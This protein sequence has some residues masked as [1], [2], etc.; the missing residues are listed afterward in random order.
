MPRYN[1]AEIE[2]KWQQFW[3][4]K[5][6]FATPEMPSGEKMY[7]LDMFPY[8]SGDGLHVGHPEGY[9]ATDIVCRYARMQGKSVL[10]PMGFDAFG[11]P[12]EEHAIKTGTPPRVQTEKNIANFT[13]QLKMLGFSYD[14][15]RQIATTD[16]EYVRWTQWI[17]LQV[18]DTWYDREQQ[19]GRPIAELPIPA[20]ISAAGA[21]AVREYQDEHRL[22]YLNEAPVNWC[23]ALGTVLANEEVIDGKSERGGH[24]VQRIPLKQWMM[25]ITDYADR[26]ESD[27]EGLDWSEGIKARQ[28]NWIGRSTGAEVDFYIGAA[29]KLADWKTSRAAGGFPRKPSDN[30]LRVYTTRPD[31]LFGA[32][33]MVIAPEHPLVDALTTSEQSAAVKAYC[34]KAAS[35][36]DLERTEL[37]KEKTG[38][39]SGSYAINPVNDEKTPIWIADYVL[40]SYGTGAIMA[41]PAHDERDFEFAQTFDI[42]VIAVVDPGESKDVERAEVLAGKVCS[43]VDGVAINSG[44]YDGTPTS[45][46]KGKIAEDLT[47]AG[48]GRTAVN[49]KL[50]D[51]LFSRQRFWGEPF[52]ILKEL[53]ADGVPNGKILPVPVDQLPVNL[54]HLEDFKPLG[55]P[56]PPLEKASHDW[57]YPIIDGVKYKRETNT[58]PQWA[59][60]CWY[61][62][63]F[64]DPTNDQVLIDREKEKAWM[65]VDLYIGGAEH[66]V[67]HLLYARFWHK[68]LFDRGVVGTAEPFQKLVNQGMILGELEYTG[69]QTAAGRWVSH[70]K[71]KT[72]AAGERIDPKT[73]EP[74]AAVKLEADAVEKQGDSFVLKADASVKIDA[75]AM[76]MSKSRG[77]VVNPDIVVKE[78]GA[79]SLRLYEMF[80]GPLEATK[81]WSMAGVSGVRN[82]LDRVWRLIVDDFAETTTLLA[83]VQEIEPTAEQNK[84][85][86]RTIEAV[87]RDLSRLEFNTPIARMMEF[88]NFFTKEEVRPKS[89]MKSLVLMLSAY[90]PHIA[91]EL[92]AVLGESETLAY[93]PW[94][95][96]DEKFTKDDEIEIPVQILGKI[97]SKIVVA[98][99]ISKADLEKA[100]LADERI[101]TLIVGKQI[102]KAIVVPGRLV[103]FVVK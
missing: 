43:T 50:R 18:Y 17:F 45:E 80:M 10:H 25:R 30:V 75:R 9:T 1:P 95:Q 73:S 62:L 39:F 28:R 8:P 84:V 42:P 85:I 34:D 72:D 12:A 56:E 15:E 98:A 33:Y 81:P 23:P 2:P 21:E 5:R 71:T 22:A 69:Y 46:F 51:W 26:L 93:H 31:T 20:E 57:L 97:R 29:D 88:T 47:T 48:L 86:H 35:K 41:V 96:F 60:S 101:Q 63:R 3:E 49:Y 13:R 99:D 87:T 64:I 27:L 14:W 103:N 94:P 68:V 61:Y 4:E 79:D 90:A 92:W 77:N 53:D 89:A 16:I 82:F 83:A 66:A 36:S 78:Y 65:P 40:I 54:P 74:V 38:V 67:L 32:T 55:R 58:M 6:T 70:N 52:P 11:L 59:G 44:K 19:R 76:K 91:E 24:P 100:A 7:V 37:A 102:V